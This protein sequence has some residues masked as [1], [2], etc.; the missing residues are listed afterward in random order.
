MAQSI[1]ENNGIENST[2][3]LIDTSTHQ[4]TKPLK[5]IE[6]GEDVAFF[7]HSK[8][9][10]DIVSFIFRLNIS[11]IPQKL[12]SEQGDEVQ[13]WVLGSEAVYSSSSTVRGLRAIL[14]RLRDHMVEIVPDTGPRRFG[15]ISF[16]KWF[17]VLRH[18]SLQL[19][20]EYL[21]DICKCSTKTGDSNTAAEELVS[22]FMGSFGSAERL[23]YG[24]GHELNFIA[25]LAGV[26]KLGGFRKLPQGEA[27]RA[28][29]TGVFEP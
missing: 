24:T 28:I 16:R 9:Y 11:L 18:E 29:V 19:L 17:D 7:I 4:Y 25:F 20:R 3:E 2:L 27:E 6:D 15:N 21:P 1:G 26:W 12:K 13:S 23:D 8:A 22:Y 5:K 14:E 10:N